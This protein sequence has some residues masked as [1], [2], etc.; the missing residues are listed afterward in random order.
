MMVLIDADELAALRD[1]LKR[2]RAREDELLGRNTQLVELAR[3]H[4]I[5]AHVA[6]FHHA[7]DLPVCGDP[8]VPPDDRVRLR[9]RVI[10]EEVFELLRAALSNTQQIDL[11]YGMI[12]AFI[13]HAPLQVNLVEF[14]DALCDLDY[15]VEGTRLE[16]GV[17]G[18]PVLA[19]I[20]ASNLSKTGSVRRADGKVLKGPNYRPPDVLGCLIRQ[21]FRP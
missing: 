4:S 19:E 9:L 2:L 1:E 15:F 6:Q 5:R 13:D 7:M 12:R 18:T 16:F 17:D 21:G 11:I 10:T 20:H 14:V 8:Q 3:S